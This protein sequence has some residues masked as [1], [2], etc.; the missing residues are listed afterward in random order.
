MS[1]EKEF[2]PT[3][4][5]ARF[6]VCAATGTDEETIQK[7][8]DWVREKG[9]TSE[10]VKIVRDEGAILVVTKREVFIK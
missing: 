6:T 9:L 3:P 1:E 2:V 7:V 8:K 10:D 5:P 4:I